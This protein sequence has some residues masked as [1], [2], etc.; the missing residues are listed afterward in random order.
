MGIIGLILT[1]LFA[2][3]I[4]RFLI[5][6]KTK[7]GGLIMTTLLGIIG[8]FVAGYLGQMLGFYQVGEP[9]GFLGAV[10]GAIIVVY[11]Y[12]RLRD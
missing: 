10:I 12:N 4:A 6:G 5:P 1:G 9:V 8:S 7:P 3:L 2:G 11:I